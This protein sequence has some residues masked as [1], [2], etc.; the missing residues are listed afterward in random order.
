[1]RIVLLLFLFVT[2]NMVVNAQEYSDK[3]ADVLHLLN[4][5]PGEKLTKTELQKRLK[6]GR[7]LQHVYRGDSLVFNPENEEAMKALPSKYVEY[8]RRY[9]DLFNH[10]L[11]TLSPVQREMMRGFWE[12]Y[13]ITSCI[14]HKFL[15]H[16]ARYWYLS[17]SKSE[18][19]ELGVTE[20]EYDSITSLIAGINA[21]HATL[22]TVYMPEKNDSR[23]LH[24]VFFPNHVMVGLDRGAGII[25]R[26]F[27]EA[28]LIMV[29]EYKKQFGN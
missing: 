16:D 27:Q 13:D 15:E 7:I 4:V 20:I 5:T 22:D 28:F 24:P 12:G 21:I 9:F 14:M 17:I 1:M 8:T 2:G 10:L 25:Y 29:E 11:E 18:V 26:R 23:F 3:T 19:L 6:L